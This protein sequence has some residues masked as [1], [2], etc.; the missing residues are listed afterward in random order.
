MSAGTLCIALILQ[1]A[2]TNCVCRSRVC[3]SSRE[4]GTRN[5]A[6]RYTQPVPALLLVVTCCGVSQCFFSAAIAVI[7][8]LES[9]TAAV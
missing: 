5:A 8:L 4:H 3:I 1:Q 2:S 6:F 9:V 7:A